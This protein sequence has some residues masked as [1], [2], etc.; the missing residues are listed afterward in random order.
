MIIIIKAARSILGVEHRCCDTTSTVYNQQ[1]GHKI[2]CCYPSYTMCNTLPNP[3][4][5]FS[6]QHWLHGPGWL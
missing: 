2:N 1:R 4:S 3:F 5:V 6:D